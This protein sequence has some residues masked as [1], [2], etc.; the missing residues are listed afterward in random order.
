[1]K[2]NFQIA[3]DILSPG[4][5]M[6]PGVVDIKLKLKSE[7]QILLLSNLISMTPGSLTLKYNE[8]ENSLKVHIMHDSE[9]NDFQETADRMQDRIMKFLK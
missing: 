1:M 9:D 7:Q 5:R 8:N 6:N 2:S 3:L 4:Y